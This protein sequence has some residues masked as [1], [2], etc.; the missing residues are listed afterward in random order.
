MTYWLNKKRRQNHF[1]WLTNV[2]ILFGLSKC[3]IDHFMGGAHHRY[4]MPML[5]VLEQ[6][7]ISTTYVLANVFVNFTLPKLSRSTSCIHSLILFVV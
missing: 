5:Y 6:I 1:P 4:I 3:F 2:L 7:M